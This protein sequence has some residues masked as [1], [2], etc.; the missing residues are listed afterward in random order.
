MRVCDGCE[1]C[2]ALRGFVIAVRFVKVSCDD[3]E[4]LG[5]NEMAVFRCSQKLRCLLRL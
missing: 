1:G 2:D 4:G 5:R 3:C